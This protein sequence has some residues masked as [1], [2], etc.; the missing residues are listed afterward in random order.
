MSYCGLGYAFCGIVR[1]NCLVRSCVVC[2]VVCLI[3][4]VLY[5]D[6]RRVES[7]EICERC[8]CV[9]YLVESPM[10]FACSL[11]CPVVCC[12]RCRVESG[13]WRVAS[14]ECGCVVWLT[15]RNQF[16]V[17]VVW[18]NSSARVA[19]RDENPCGWCSSDKLFPCVTM[20]ETSATLISLRSTWELISCERTLIARCIPSPDVFL[21]RTWECGA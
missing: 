13:D 7:G 1:V 11:G 19:T 2:V 3:C 18:V 8:A 15:C 9:E 4:S 20:S 12:V 6:A 16:L 17:S 10:A 21:S 5:C 14:G